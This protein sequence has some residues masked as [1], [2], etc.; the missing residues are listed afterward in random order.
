MYYL[1]FAALVLHC[2]LWAF[3]GCGKWGQLFTAVHG[4]LIVVTSFVAKHRLQ[5]S[6]ASVVVASGLTSCSSPALEFWYIGL[7]APWHMESSQTWDQT[8]IPCTART[9]NHWAMRE[10]QDN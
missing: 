5:S 7:I 1:C 10:V 4:L 3:S 9:P 8:H 2:C 6:Q